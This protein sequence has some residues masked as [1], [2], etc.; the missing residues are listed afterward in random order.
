MP[1]S[2]QELL[3]I[4]NDPNSSAMSNGR[5]VV[6]NLIGDAHASVGWHEITKALRVLLSKTPSLCEDD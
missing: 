3:A 6:R 2:N 5:E 4:L 1:K